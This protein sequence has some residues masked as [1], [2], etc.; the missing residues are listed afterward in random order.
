MTSKVKAGDETFLYIG[1][2]TMDEAFPDIQG[3]TWPW[4][5]ADLEGFSTT[6]K[7]N[8]QIR[9]IGLEWGG[10]GYPNYV[11]PSV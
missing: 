8:S 2:G 5:R 1:H 10:Q 6:P 3:F 7:D 9:W 4:I 11:L